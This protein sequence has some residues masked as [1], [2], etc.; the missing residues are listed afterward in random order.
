VERKLF[1]RSLREYDENRNAPELT[2]CT[3]RAT[4]MAKSLWLGTP[5]NPLRG[6][7]DVG[8]PQLVDPN[9]PDVWDL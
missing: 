1:L 8:S 9:W 5:K 2:A 3:P 6:F 4:P 7:Y